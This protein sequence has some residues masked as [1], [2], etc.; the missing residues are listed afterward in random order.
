M[1]KVIVVGVG[2]QGSTVAKRLQEEKVVKEIVCADYDEKAAKEMEKTLPKAKA[3]K[4]DARKV[5]EIIKAAKGCDLVVNGL[6]PDFNMNVMKA[7]LEVG[8]NYQDMASGPVS[9]TDFVTAV[10]RCLD[11]DSQFKAKKLTALIN[12]GSAPGFANILTREAVEMLDSCDAINIY[13][14]DEI[15]SKKFI[16]FWWSPATAFGDMA[17][18]PIVYEN[19]KHVLKDPF[20]EEVM[21]DFRGV[22]KKRMV[23]HEHEEPVTMGLLAN[24]VL[25]GVKY[26]NF[27]YGG[28]GLDLAQY[29]YKMGLLSEKEINVKGTKIVPMDIISKLTPPAPKYPN[30]I[31]A[32]LKEGMI[33]EDG[34]FLVRA[35]GTQKGRKVTIDMYANAPGLTDAFKKAK[36]THESYFTGQ[37]AFLFT[38]MLVN[39][40]VATRG[41][42]P[43]EVMEAAERAYYLKEAA[44]L[45]LTVDMEI[46]S[47][48]Y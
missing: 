35:E 30:E 12:T 40:K 23:N 42:F 16:P 25:K 24:K 46:R 20:S 36:I 17:A 26:V 18:K 3:V 19:G 10:K 8:A 21:M 13:V 9:D 5:E 27:K 41:V 32:V 2:A 15:W 38:K 33:S 14:Y 34:A 22:G 37:A 31:K 1:N 7:A 47:R 4:L 11:M 29:F 6:E 39:D 43:P 28:P 44:K 45:D 48:L